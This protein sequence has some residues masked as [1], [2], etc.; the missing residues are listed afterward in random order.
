MRTLVV[1]LLLMLCAGCGTGD[2]SVEHDEDLQARLKELS[3]NGGSARFA[4]LTG[5]EWD[6][7]YVF[8]EGVSAERVER[9]VGAPVLDDEFYYE[10][11]NLLVFTRGGEVTSAVSV[12]PDLLVTGGKARWSTDA[13]LEPQGTRTPAALR[14]V[15]PSG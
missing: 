2:V 1:G 9:E 5:R 3:S 15:E 11:G 6:A 8:S 7:V 12:L 14:L 4:D 10:A 13:R